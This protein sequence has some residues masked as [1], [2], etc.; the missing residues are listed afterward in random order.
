[1][2]AYHNHP[3]CFKKIQMSRVHLWR[4]T[5]TRSFLKLSF[6][7]LNVAYIPDALGIS[8]PVLSAQ[9]VYIQSF[10]G[11]FKQK[12]PCV[13]ACSHVYSS[14]LH[15]FASEFPNMINPDLF[16]LFLAEANCYSMLPDHG[17][18]IFLPRHTQPSQA[19]SKM[20]AKKPCLCSP[21]PSIVPSISI[22]SDGAI[23]LEPKEA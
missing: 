11:A 4:F 8:F 17:D 2:A 16:S 6:L 20:A 1:M 21:C 13:P 18:S 19:D 14:R 7:A 5:F 3:C 15:E 22:M 12:E 9:R 23:Y 10:N